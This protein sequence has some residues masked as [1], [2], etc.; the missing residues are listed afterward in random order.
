[1]RTKRVFTGGTLYLSSVHIK[2]CPPSGLPLGSVSNLPSGFLGS[3][4]G[5]FPGSVRH[6]AGDYPRPGA[7]RGPRRALG[8]ALSAPPSRD[9]PRRLGL[10]CNP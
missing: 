2:R 1:M 8:V 9:K 10:G 7:P 3:M 5:R 4:M 6:S